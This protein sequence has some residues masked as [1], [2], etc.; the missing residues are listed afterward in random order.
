MHDYLFFF[1]APIDHLILGFEQKF[2]VISII[3]A[4]FSDIGVEIVVKDFSICRQMPRLVFLVISAGTSAI[5]QNIR[6]QLKWDVLI[7][8]LS[9]QIHSHECHHEITIRDIE[10]LGIQA[11]IQLNKLFLQLLTCTVGAWAV[12]S[13]KK[14]PCIM[15]A[16]L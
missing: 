8:L 15:K 4:P 12:S 14:I 11:I 3:L 10:V 5:N 13:A 16:S 7:S 9:L 6:V 2:G 1:Q